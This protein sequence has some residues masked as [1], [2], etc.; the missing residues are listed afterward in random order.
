[1]RQSFSQRHGY[2]PLPEPMRPEELSS[3]LRRE[4]WNAVREFLLEERKGFGSYHFDEEAQRFIERVI[5]N[6]KKQPEDMISALAA[7]NMMK[8]SGI[9]EFQYL[10][11][12]SI[13]FWI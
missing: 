7:L 12:C 1:M 9:S 10:N 6:H 4:I 2:E 5:G 13:K 3:D 11:I 8:Y